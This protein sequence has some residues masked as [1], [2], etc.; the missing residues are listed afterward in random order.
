MKWPV[1]YARMLH[2]CKQDNSVSYFSSYWN[3]NPCPEKAN[4]SGSTPFAIKY[5]DI[6]LQSGSN[7]LIGWKLEMGVAS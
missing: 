3:F 7:N 5:V 2:N 6:Y 1:Y 4:W